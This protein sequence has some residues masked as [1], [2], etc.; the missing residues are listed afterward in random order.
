LVLGLVVSSEE[1]QEIVYECV[2]CGARVTRKNLEFRGGRVRCPNER[3]RSSV[4]K[5]VR[6]PIAK[7]IK[8]E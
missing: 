7:H 5:K 1:E 2:I 3:C 4:L 8:C 6:P